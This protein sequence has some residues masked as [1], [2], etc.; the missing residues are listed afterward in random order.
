MGSNNF[1]FI[2]DKLL[3]DLADLEKKIIGEKVP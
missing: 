1:K 2:L 3:K